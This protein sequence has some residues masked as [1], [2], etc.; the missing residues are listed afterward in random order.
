MSARCLWVAAALMT[1]LITTSSL[2][3][4]A[5]ARISLRW[6]PVEGAAGYELEIAKDPQ[7]R[8][9]VVR[10]R[11][12]VAG[13][14]WDELPRITYFW[15]VRSLDADNRAGEWSEAERIGS[16]VGAPEP[17]SPRQG[18]VMFLEGATLDLEL[19]AHASPL[20][21]EYAFELS[22]DPSFAREVQVR[23]SAGATARFTVDGLGTWHW[24][25]RGTDLSGRDAGVSPTQ[26]VE[27]R[28]GAPE[29]QSPPSS[30][31]LPWSSGTNKVSI[32]WKPQPQ[33]R[34]YVVEVSEGRAT[35][36]LRAQAPELELSVSSPTPISWRVAAVERSGR[37]TPFSAVRTLKFSNG[38]ATPT[39]PAAKSLVR[40][41]GPS[42]PVHF[43]W[44][45]PEGAT[46]AE[47]EVARGANFSAPILRLKVQGTSTEAAIPGPGTYAW[48]V[49]ARGARGMPFGTSEA[50]PFEVKLGTPPRA[51][52]LS[53]P[54]RD[55]VIT[56]DRGVQVS[57]NAVPGAR[58]Y[59]LQVDDGRPVPAAVVDRPGHRLEGLPEGEHA[60]RVR[61]VDEAGLASAWSDAVAFHL[62]TPRIAKVELNATDGLTMNVGATSDLRFRLLDSRGR[63]VRDIRPAVQ[64]SAGVVEAVTADG[65]GFRMRYVPPD[66]IPPSGEAEL[67]VADRGFEATTRLR[68]VGKRR[69]VQL[70]IR[71]GWS[72]AFSAL[73][74]PY[75]G[76]DATWE[77]GWWGNRIAVSARVG[78]HGGVTS[79]PLGDAGATYSVQTRVMPVAALL[80]F[81]SS[82]GGWQARVGAGPGVHVVRSWIGERSEVLAVPSATAVAGLS[83]RLGPGRA[84]V[85]A[86]YSLGVTEGDVARGNTGGLLATFGYGVDL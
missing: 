86:G 38:S 18:A 34:T 2:G 84:L 8:E 74:S 69:R 60:V 53:T 73:T 29:P 56:P 83:R 21:R 64:V 70:G 11:T 37:Q 40:V 6:K 65:D 43:A 49:T 67:R 50:T 32:R 79:V 48:R 82:F 68:L 5:S 13:Y 3:A 35:R 76:M 19:T 63:I 12:K 41:A 77:P 78:L 23:R 80:L 61:A 57:W 10:E 14:R 26:R 9:I 36:T 7:F 45:L 59:E 15:R 24:R 16:A 1:A 28:L 52:V 39:A 33:A 17:A 55:S 27:V 30:A 66:D 51:P 44:T 62:G 4:A 71:T 46:G 85:E 22:R 42:Q 47:I 58:R 31:A 54:A 72:T 75:L 25:I 20:L 81:Q